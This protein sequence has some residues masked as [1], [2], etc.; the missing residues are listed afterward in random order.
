MNEFYS[1]H[2]QATPLLLANVWDAPSAKC[3]EQAGYQAM[4]TS[5]AALAAVLGYEDGENIPF[6]ELLFVVKRITASSLLPLS[7]DIESGF[8]SDPLVI[9]NHIQQLAELG[10]V[11]INIEDSR[12]EDSRRLCDKDEFSELLTQVCAH[13]T[14]RDVQIFINVRCDVFLLGVEGAAEEACMRARSYQM[15]GADG[16]FFPCITA[17]Q[18]IRKVTSSTS[19]PINVMAMP[20]LPSVAKLTELGVKRI[21]TGNFAHMAIYERLSA[22]LT[23]IKTQGSCQS[24]FE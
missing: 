2:Q 16:L 11:G 15:A 13:L 5:S 4:G 22:T 20:E 14:A 7:V 8:S 24:L 3:A 21:S 18:D 9:A 17:E 10:V 19:L 1:L 12:V 6:E 23:Q